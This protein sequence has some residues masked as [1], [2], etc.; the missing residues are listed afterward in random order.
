MLLINAD[1]DPMFKRFVAQSVAGTEFEPK[2]ADSGEDAW[3]LV[4]SAAT[5]VV[6]LYG[7]GLADIDGPE[8]CAR[9][10]QLRSPRER[11]TIATLGPGEAT[12]LVATIEA[13]ADDVLVKPFSSQVLLSRLR[14]AARRCAAPERMVGTVRVAL[15]EALADEIGGEVVVR[16]KDRVGRVHVSNRKVAWAHVSGE[17]VRIG[18]LVR[19]AGVTLDEDAAA[20]V[21]EESRRLGVHFADILVRRGYLDEARARECIRALVAGQLGQLLAMP[22]A[23]AMFLPRSRSYGSPLSFPLSDVAPAPAPRAVSDAVAV[24]SQRQPI[25]RVARNEATVA[26]AMTIDGAIGAAILGQSTAAPR[27]CAGEALD[28]ELTWFLLGTL[29]ALGKEAEDAIAVQ[30]DAAFL[31]RVIDDGGALVVAFS[32]ARTTLGLAR[33]SLK[34]LVEA[35]RLAPAPADGE[36]VWRG[37]REGIHG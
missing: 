19:S 13:G 26:E 6:L 4:Q 21:I 16:G 31:A 7:W 1:T 30:R 17:P 14:L 20:S 22:D 15:D 36:Q 3:A 25:D 34:R 33:S 24:I 9:L 27:A 12:E 5:P 10:R 32:L 8:M 35:R 28:G 23:A 29:V 11:Y 37:S 2:L 18:E